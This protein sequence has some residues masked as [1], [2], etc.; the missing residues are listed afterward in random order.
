[1]KKLVFFLALLAFVAMAPTVRAQPIIDFDVPG[2]AMGTISYAGG[3]APLVGTNITSDLVAGRNV[4]V[5]NN[6]A[7]TINGGLLNFTTGNSNGSWSWAAGG[8]ISINGSIPAQTPSGGTPFA[9]TSGTLLSGTLVSAIVT[10]GPNSN[11]FFVAI[12]AFVNSINSAILSYYGISGSNPQVG[13]FNLSFMV[14]GGASAPNAF[15]STTMGS[16][17]VVG[18]VPAPGFLV[19]L[20]S[21][22]AV[23]LLGYAWRRT[24]TLAV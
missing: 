1:V 11:T 23:S 14:S 17:D 8:S 22:G 6:V 13:N 18:T 10:P 24:R 21:G 16:G 20:C 12:G 3:S 9:G 19:L 4:P 7:L 2:I 15:T 5:N